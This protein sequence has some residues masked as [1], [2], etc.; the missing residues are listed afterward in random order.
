MLYEIKNNRVVLRHREDGNVVCSLG[1]RLI[2]D[3]IAL[4]PDRLDATGRGVRATFTH[5]DMPAATIEDSLD[6]L[7]GCI[8]IT[9]ETVLHAS[10]DY[11]IAHI[12]SAPFSQEP[13]LFV[14]AVLYKGNLAG[15]GAFPRKTPLENEWA[16]IESRT[17][18]PAATILTAGDRGFAM[19]CDPSRSPRL[20][21]SASTRT[22]SAGAETT[23]WEPGYE[24]PKRYTGK[25]TL[26]AATCS[27]SSTWYHQAEGM[28]PL[29][30]TITFHILEGSLGDNGPFG[31]Y[32]EFV[33]AYRRSAP[34]DSRELTPVSWQ[35]Y[36]ELKF[37]H[38]L[39]LVEPIES[40]K[41]ACLVMGRGNGSLQD[42][43]EYTAGSFLVKSLEAA[44]ILARAEASPLTQAEEKMLR[45][46]C[47]R[48]GTPTC[49]PIDLSIMIGNFF[50]QGE[51]APGVHQDCYDRKR[52]IWGGYLGIS[53]HDDFRHL[54]NARCNGEVM[55]SYISLYEILKKAG[56][57]RTEFIELP[58]RVA[59]FCIKHQFTG[60]RDGSFG[61]WWSPEG[62]AVNSLGTNGAYIVSFLCAIEPYMAPG[63]GV[64]QAIRRATSYY[65]QLVDAGEYFGDTLDADSCDKEA[66]VTLM[67]MF[68]DLYER[69]RNT[70]WLGYARK[71]AEFV[72]TWIWQYDREFPESAPLAEKNFATTGMTS[73]SVAHHHLDFYGML[74]AYGYLRLWEHSGEEFF[75]D[76]GRLM[77]DACRQLIATEDDLLGRGPE[78]IGWQPEQINHT[79]W[80][81]FD[82]ASHKHGSFDIDIAWVTVLGLGAYQKIERRYPDIFSD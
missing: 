79:D 9:R 3:S 43:Y 45:A 47:G 53:E 48:M 34:S 78:D 36:R 64:A 23:V 31:L 28:E 52:K 2:V 24:S 26:D 58:K 7:N 37:L 8:T 11:R 66:G 72:A 77:L 54:I 73:V 74:I 80:D 57:T 62:R 55:T 25:K 42:V 82:R 49:S 59:R 14:P 15:K 32:R 51:R 56:H 30:L 19:C 63:D 1:Y 68:L 16:F 76:Q 46:V 44:V 75:R 69:D 17:P 4:E 21:I 6:T 60:R 5:N 22:S 81:Y 61:R 27:E 13:T 29:R 40:G 10:A 50:L 71:A 12:F 70:R 18:L 41:T 67:N 20:P 39:S 35:K 33:N 38:L 65:G